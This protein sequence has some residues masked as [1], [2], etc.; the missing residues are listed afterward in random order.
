MTGV[1]LYRGADRPD[2]KPLVGRHDS[3]DEPVAEVSVA[4]RARAALD[5]GACLLVDQYL[6]HRVVQEFGPA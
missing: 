4:P 6:L 5:S 2:P 3:G 1:G